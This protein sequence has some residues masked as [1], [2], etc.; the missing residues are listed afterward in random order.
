MRRVG[1]DANAARREL[2]SLEDGEAHP[3]VVTAS[4]AP[5]KSQWIAVGI[6]AALGLIPTL[7][8]WVGEPFSWLGLYAG[9]TRLITG[10]LL[11]WSIY[12][13]LVD[14]RSTTAFHSHPLQ[15]DIFDIRPFQ[16]I[17]GHSLTSALALFGGGAISLF[18]TSWDRA[19]FD[20]STVVFY[21]G[22]VLVAALAFYLPTRATHRVLAAARSEELTRVQQQI[23]AAYRSLGALPPESEDLGLLP[24][25]LNLW[26]EYEERVKRTRTWPYDLSML[27]T[28]ALSV[29]TPIGIA[30]AQRLLSQLFDL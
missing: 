19:S 2:V 9:V 5:P 27:R 10:G 7:L 25:K 11:G 22:L 3:P 8:W 6:G 28:F 29:L 26:K 24:S 15:V 16:R 4:T 18:L 17:S 12:S 1:A 30:L 20:P 14:A 23:V 21:A 13:A